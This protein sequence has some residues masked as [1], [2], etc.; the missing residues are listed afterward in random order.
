MRGGCPRAGALMR[1]EP[2]GAIAAVCMPGPAG[3]MAPGAPPGAGRASCACIPA[4]RR[5]AWAAGR[6]RRGCP[7]RRIEGAGAERPRCDPGSRRRSA[8]SRGISCG[9]RQAAN[10]QA[11]A[12]F[13]APALP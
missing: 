3:S 6:G 2:S 1:P 12:R 11:P 7:I 10:R 5:R 13:S 8:G 4:P 9:G